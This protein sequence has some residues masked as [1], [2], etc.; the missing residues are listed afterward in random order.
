MRKLLV[1][2]VVLVIGALLGALTVWQLSSRP[3][4]NEFTIGETTFIMRG[5]TSEERKELEQTIRD[6]YPILEEIYGEVPV[7]VRGE[8]IVEIIII[9][10]ATLDVPPDVNVCGVGFNI[11]G[12]SV[13]FIG[14]ESTGEGTVGHELAHAFFGPVSIRDAPLYHEGFA[15]ALETLVSQRLDRIFQSERASCR[16]PEDFEFT[17]TE[18]KPQLAGD[19]RIGVLRSAQRVLSQRLWLDVLDQDPQFIAT[20]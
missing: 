7:N 10:E 1:P 2:L 12:S 3:E 15:D 16:L 18:G 20:R 14:L 5:W 19:W 6:A 17:L 4:L 13:Y 9:K 8:P 11:L